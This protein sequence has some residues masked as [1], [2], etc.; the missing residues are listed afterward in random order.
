MLIIGAVLV[1]L[2]ALGA[3]RVIFQEKPKPRGPVSFS[4]L[5]AV[6]SGF[7]DFPTAPTPI[8]STTGSQSTSPVSPSVD[9]TSGCVVTTSLLTNLYDKPELFNRTALHELPQNQ[10]YKVLEKSVYHH[11]PMD[12]RFFRI[13]DANDVEGWVSAQEL[14][15]THPD[16]LK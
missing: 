12:I 11:G 16:C 4:E 10:S 8:T 9:L 1:F 2:V 15:K 3:V 14:S 13:K 5:L 6:F 7:S